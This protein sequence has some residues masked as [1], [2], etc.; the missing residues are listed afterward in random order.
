MSGTFIQVPPDSTGQK[1]R[2]RSRTIGADTVLEQAVFQGALPTYYAV[3]DNVAF[4]NG[5]TH[6]SIVNAAGSG[7]LVAIRKLFAVNLSIAAVTGAALR[8]DARRITAHSGGTTVTPIKADTAN[9]NLPAQITVLTNGTPTG[10]TLLYPF[11]VTT[12]E[13]AAT[14]AFTKNMFMAMTNL[15][16]EGLEIQELRLREGEGFAITQITASTV[17]SFAWFIVFTVDDA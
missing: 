13:E 8:M 4:A 10:P 2:M 1:L 12:E 14:A 5:K 17:G 16:P 7:K 6:L 11:I 9:D 15:Q 3:A